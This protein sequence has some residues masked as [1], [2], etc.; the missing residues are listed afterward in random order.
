MHA[1]YHPTKCNVTGCESPQSSLF[2]CSRHEALY[3]TSERFVRLQSEVVALYDGKAADS[4]RIRAFL[5]SLLHY[6]TNAKVPYLEHFPLESIYLQ[7]RRALLNRLSSSTNSNKLENCKELNRLI[8]DFDHPANE[9]L[10]DLRLR[11][12]WHCGDPR[13]SYN[14][15]LDFSKHLRELVIINP[16][17]YIY[18]S[19]LAL[20]AFMGIV[21]SERNL[22][23]HIQFPVVL[24]AT[25]LALMYF[26][27]IGMVVG[28]YVFLDRINPV[29]IKAQ[30]HRLYADATDNRIGA[31]IAL[32]IQGRFQLHAGSD[33]S[34]SSTVL[35][36]LFCL[37]T[38]WPLAPNLSAPE[39]GA[40]AAAAVLSLLLL[41]PVGTVYPIY[42]NASVSMQSLPQG[43][44]RVD[45]HAADGRLGIGDLVDLILAGTVFNAVALTVLWI[46]GP[47]AVGH[48]A[49]GGWWTFGVYQLLTFP[50]AVFRVAQLR[51][52]WGVRRSVVN[53]VQLAIDEEMSQ[54]GKLP[55][56]ERIAR[57]QSSERA[58]R[59]PILTAAFR[60]RVK[61]FV[62]VVLI[63]LAMLVCDKI[64]TALSSGA[65]SP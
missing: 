63:P 19:T 21:Y 59:F 44:F 35:L 17:I 20:A 36:A 16:R 8:D 40:T 52:L 3:L 5:W 1:K 39:L 38:P 13:D 43:R 24:T 47:L 27:C 57:Q 41:Y 61:E 10:E 34:T 56:S 58:R 49:Q 29:L 12:A 45:L 30:S 7:H 62:T 60:G 55:A 26:V 28:G 42:A 51:T 33:Y 15:P 11:R 65:P 31:E 64:Y 9:T 23:F 18:L 32:R 14:R 6:V 54:L 48:V 2:L 25:R 53:S 37:L 50:I 22:N 46:L 4:L